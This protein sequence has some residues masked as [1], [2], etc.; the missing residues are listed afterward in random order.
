ME[1]SKREFNQLNY[2]TRNWIGFLLEQNK[3]RREIASKLGMAASSITREINRNS[4]LV[5]GVKI[6]DPI[7]A[8]I[9]SEQRQSSGYRRKIQRLPE[10]LKLI[11]KKL[12]AGWSPDAISG[13]L[14][15]KRPDLYVSHES[16]YLFIYQ[17]KRDWIKLLPR[18]K[19]R[20]SHR[21][22]AY[23]NRKKTKIPDRVG[24]DQRP[25]Y[26]DSRK[27]FGHFE[28]DCIVSRKSKAALLVVTERK[29][30]WTRIYKLKQ[31][32]AREVKRALIKI[33]GKYAKSVKT[34]TYDN[35]TENVL[36]MEINKKLNCKSYFCNPYHSWEKGTVE[37]INGLIRRYVKKSMD[38]DRF[39]EKQIQ[40]IERRLNRIPRKILSYF[41][42]Q[43]YFM[44]EWCNCA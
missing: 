4:I 11:E 10:L 39:S 34:I 29:T 23:L 16:I 19:D 36:H 12:E 1:K 15:R 5:E 31:K 37:N 9:K 43:E 28:A 44:K 6:Y 22:N 27:S 42:P 38:I 8:Q 2:R 18:G 24:I 21:K 17:E 13:H 30:K 14:K 26:V 40:K 20:R 41:S 35:G 33:L 32:T 7:E 25:S 3:T